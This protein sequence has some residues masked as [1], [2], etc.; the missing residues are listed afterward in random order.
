[1]IS[2]ESPSGH[3]M[4]QDIVQRSE[5][6]VSSVGGSGFPDSPCLKLVGCAVSSPQGKGYE[7]FSSADVF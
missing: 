5:L 6:G 3:V 7:Q 1:M 2:N 4:S